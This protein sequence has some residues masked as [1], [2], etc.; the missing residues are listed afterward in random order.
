M[1]LEQCNKEQ[2]IFIIN[3]LL[4]FYGGAKY[5]INMALADIEQQPDVKKIEEAEAWADAA[6]KKRQEYVSLLS[7]EGSKLTL[8]TIR[9]ANKLIKLADQADKKYIELM[10]GI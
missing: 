8:E 3:R 7:N 2:L 4:R 1:T 10:K 5:H 6:D 9:K